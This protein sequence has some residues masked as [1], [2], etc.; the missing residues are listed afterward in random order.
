MRS[1]RSTW[2][3]G[4][5]RLTR[6]RRASTA[7]NIDDELRFHFEQKVEEFVAAEASPADARCRAEEEFG[8]VER[9]RASLN[10]IDDRVA[11]KQRRAEWWEGALQDLRYVF[12]TLR[13]SPAF[14][15]TVVVTLGLGANGALF[16]LLDRLY[17]QA[18]SGIVDAPHLQ[19][20]YQ[21][22]PNNGRPFT[23]AGLSYPEIRALREVAPVG[24]RLAGYEAGR[25]RLG[26]APDAP[27]VGVAYV[28]GDYF[29]VAGAQPGRGRFFAPD[30]S[31]IE[32]QAMV[33]VIS[34]ALW[35][36]Q[37]NGH[38]DVIGREL[39]LGSHRHVIVGVA[40]DAF[41]GLDLGGTDVWVPLSTYGTLRG[42]D[43]AWFETT[44]FNGIRVVARVPM[45]RRVA[46]SMHARRR[47]CI[48]CAFPAMR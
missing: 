1:R 41:H 16:S 43:P 34:H 7:A 45:R 26:R 12:R 15:A 18:P 4:W 27:E 30:E 17:V 10:V 29:G 42:R 20:V 48:A 25:V 39:D 6:V 44:D 13:R 32:G 28:E 37:F 8:D 21:F 3:E 2:T 35:L 36:R 23:R 14:T 46:C 40:R 38:V 9:V 19:R 33:A 22:M 5:R 31:R 24:I 47:R 11:K